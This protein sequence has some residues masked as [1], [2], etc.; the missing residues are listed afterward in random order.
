MPRYKSADI[1]NVALIGHQGTGK[2]SLTEAMLFVAKSVDRLGNVRDGTAT[3]DFEPEEAS[4]QQSLST[5]LCFAVWGDVKVNI[6]D[7]PGYA[8][9]MPDVEAALQVTDAA[10]LVIDA[11]E[12][13]QVHT[14]KVYQ[15]AA[16]LQTPVV[17]VINKLDSEDADVARAAST[18]ADSL[19]CRPV[20]VQIPIMAGDQLTGLID[21][22]H[23]KALTYSDGR[24]TTDEIPTELAEEAE[25]A[26]AELLEFVAEADDELLEKYLGDEELTQEEVVQGLRS[27]VRQRL[28][29]PVLCCVAEAGRGADLLLDFIAE[30][31]P[32]PA[33]LEGRRAERVADGEGAVCSPADDG[34]LSAVVFKTMVDHFVGRVSLYRVYSGTLTSNATVYNATQQSRERIGQLLSLQ[35]KQQEA[36]TELAAG[37]MGAVAK[38]A[39]TQTGDTL[40]AEDRAVVFDQLSSAEGVFSRSATAASRADEEKLSEAIARLAE[41]DVGL[42][43]VR[44]PDTGEFVVSGMG[45]VHL[46]VAVERLQRKFGVSVE[47]GEPK[48]AYRETIRGPADA[49][50]RH[51]KQTGGRGQFAEC[52]I[53]I[54]PLSRGE[55]FEFVNEIRG[56]AIKGQ[57]VPGVQ[58]GVMEAMQ[59]GVV[60]GYPVVDVKVTVYDGKDHPVD[61]SELAF[62][63]AGGSAFREASRNA[64]PVLLEPIADVEVTTPDEHVG[65]II[66]DLNGK[67]GR[68]L[69]TEPQGTTQVVRAQVPLGEI[70]GYETD[71]RRMTQGRASYAA[72]FSHYEDVPQHLAERIVAQH[73]AETE[74]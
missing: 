50:Q 59:R 56:A 67:R 36:V 20:R 61:S 35:G 48:V 40:C 72:K 37:D 12:G 74:E 70:A 27:A 2:T 22:V 57:Y 71:L 52:A 17:A 15:A 32:S 60:A 44:D 19:Q 42:S 63:V 29:V 66:S 18:L 4:R 54:E 28:C 41:E 45:Q 49:R 30:A 1:R 68:V 34:L 73:K 3:T 8:D 55:G 58:K 46:D 10:I 43:W 39:V 51:K 26:R 21:L 69:G 24:S 16:A 7:T 62:K 47:L 38:L 25:A 11:V 65:D 9:F 6:L 31:L 14:E 5:A 64:S 53:R 23:M 33:D 13:V